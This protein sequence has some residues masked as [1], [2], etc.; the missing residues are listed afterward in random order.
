MDNEA[1]SDDYDET[2]NDQSEEAE[3]SRIQ[4]E[5]MFNECID[6]DVSCFSYLPKLF[7]LDSNQFGSNF[8][9]F[10]S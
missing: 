1:D 6:K 3:M 9:A 8:Y 10:I 7:L 5:R 2:L 4:Q